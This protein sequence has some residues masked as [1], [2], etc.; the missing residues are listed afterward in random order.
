MVVVVV[1]LVVFFM[2]CTSL[3]DPVVGSVD[4]VPGGRP[5]VFIIRDRPE[6]VNTF[7]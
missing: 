5:V 6:Y 4:F 2:V 7:F 3:L 1:A